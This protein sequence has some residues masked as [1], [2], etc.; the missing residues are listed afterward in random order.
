MGNTWAR[1]NEQRKKRD[2]ARFISERSSPSSDTRL[3]TANALIWS[4]LKMEGVGRGNGTLLSNI[5]LG[6]AIAWEPQK[7][8]REST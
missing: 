4:R 6:E 5:S 2:V 1:C 7:S 8:I 3:S